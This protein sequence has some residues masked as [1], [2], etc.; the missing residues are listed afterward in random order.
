MVKSAS[1]LVSR[2]PREVS[3]PKASA[4]DRATMPRA[5]KPPWLKKGPTLTEIP[6]RISSRVRPPSFYAERRVL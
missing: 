4:P 1:H 6:G 5:G 3:D 2:R